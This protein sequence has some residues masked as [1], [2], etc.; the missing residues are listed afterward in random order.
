MYNLINFV[1]CIHLWSHRHNAR[2]IFN[3]CLKSLL[4]LGSW[5]A[6]SLFALMWLSALPRGS[7]CFPPLTSFLPSHR[8][9]FYILAS[10]LSDD[11]CVCLYLC[12]VSVPTRLQVGG[13]R[14][15]SVLFSVQFSLPPTVPT[16]GR[17]SVESRLW[18]SES[19]CFGAWIESIG[20]KCSETQKVIL[21]FSRGKSKGRKAS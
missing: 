18:S 3:A 16:H 11:Y 6:T 15:I 14:T 20:N 9:H 2:G 10:E 8:L 13:T 17:C 21:I 12:W 19:W 1:I 4:F 5:S 7:V